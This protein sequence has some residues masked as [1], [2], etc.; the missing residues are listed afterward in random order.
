MIKITFWAEFCIYLPINLSVH[1]PLISLLTTL[2]IYICNSLSMLWF[3]FNFDHHSQNQYVQ[4]HKQIL[5]ITPPADVLN[6]FLLFLLIFFTGSVWLLM[7]EGALFIEWTQSCIQ[8]AIRS[9]LVRTLSAPVHSRESCSLQSHL[10][11]TDFIYQTFKVRF[12]ESNF[13][14]FNF[15]LYLRD[16]SFTVVW[17]VL[18]MY[19]ARHNK[20]FI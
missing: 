18:V 19:G 2:E 7:K 13:K 20:S 5:L 14:E 16:L 6:G 8:A 1:H 4:I 9:R 11:V 3:N 15:S 10:R 17:Y 12:V